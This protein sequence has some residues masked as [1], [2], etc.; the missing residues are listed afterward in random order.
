MESLLLIFFRCE[1]R[2]GRLS[3][4]MQKATFEDS[5]HISFDSTNLFKGKFATSKQ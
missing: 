4:E 2:L 5:D 3:N 1:A